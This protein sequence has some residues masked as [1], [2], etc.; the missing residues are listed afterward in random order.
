M[1]RCHH[2]PRHDP[3]SASNYQFIEVSHMAIKWDVVFQ[4]KMLMG[5]AALTCKV[6]QKTDKIVSFLDRVCLLN[7][8]TLQRIPIWQIFSGAGCTWS[9]NPFCHSEYSRHGIPYRSQ[10][11]HL[12]WLQNDHLPSFWPSECW[13]GTVR[14]PVSHKISPLFRIVTVNYGT[15]PD[16]TALQWMKKEQTADKKAPYLFSQCQAIHARS[17]IPCM[18]TPSVKTTYE[19]EV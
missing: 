3:C 19:A 1:C 5:S 12:F 6:I 18:D 17:I 10:R 16:A 8:L 13:T 2:R 7:G 14:V 4:L 15:S 11:L 9:V